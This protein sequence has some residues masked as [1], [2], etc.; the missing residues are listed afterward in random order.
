MG[1]RT[2]VEGP[3]DGMTGIAGIN[4]LILGLQGVR[5][6]LVLPDSASAAFTQTVWAHHAPNACLEI[7]ERW[8]G[9]RLPFGNGEFDLAW[10]FNVMT[11]QAD[12]RSVLAELCRVSRTVVLICVPNRSHYAF[13]LH[14]LQH[15]VAKQ[16][17]DHGNVDLMQPEP[18]QRMFVELGL[19]VRKTI[20]LDC[21]WWPDIVDAEQLIVDFF[22]SLKRLARRARPENRYR[23]RAGE[24]P[25]YR[26]DRYPEVFRRMA[27]LA[28]FE[29]SRPDWLKRHFAH[30]IGVLAEKD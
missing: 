4:S 9:S 5:V 10:N 19:R 6:S 28:Y 29:N 25:Y 17:W 30:H 24:L 15:R 23:W 16:P 8:E 18:W 12:P 2:L 3:G 11:R 20:W 27:R 7:V 1:I 21:P 22:P 14:R 26:P 13:G